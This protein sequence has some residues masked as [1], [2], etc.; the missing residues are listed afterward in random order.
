MIKVAGCWELGW[1]TPFSEYDLWHFPMREYEVDEWIMTPISGIDKKGITEV[2]TIE[3]AIELNK[4]LTP[5]YV[6]EKGKNDLLNFNHPKDVL[7]ILGRT[8]YSPMISI[9]KYDSI[10]IITPRGGDLLWPHQA[11]CMVLQDRYI[12]WQS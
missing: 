1:N 3:K 10:R 6:D 9:G 7:Y 5:I 12:K 8:T 11:I 2:E 4:N